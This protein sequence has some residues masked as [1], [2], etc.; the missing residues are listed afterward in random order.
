MDRLNFIYKFFKLKQVSKTRY[1]NIRIKTQGQLFNSLDPSP[2]IEKD[3]DDD[4]IAYIVSYFEEFALNDRIDILIHLPKSQRKKT[5]EKII[6]KA[7]HNYFFYRKELEL[8]KIKKQID[9][10]KLSLIIGFFILILSMAIKFFVVGY[11][12][13]YWLSVI[14]SE[15][16]TIGGWVAMWKPLGEIL[17]AWLPMKRDKEIYKKISE[18]NVDFIYE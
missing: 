5:S 8:H 11:I 2:F 12:N 7:I 14:L 13:Y 18:S 3:L 15:G 10:S 4:A 16:L 9:S 17:Y 1:I 6:R